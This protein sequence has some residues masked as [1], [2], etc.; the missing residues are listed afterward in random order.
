M[1]IIDK[2]AISAQKGRMAAEQV[3]AYRKAIA[4]LQANLADAK[5]LRQ[6]AFMAIRARLPVSQ[7]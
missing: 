4:P 7:N 6:R 5:A 1:T 2:L 3:E